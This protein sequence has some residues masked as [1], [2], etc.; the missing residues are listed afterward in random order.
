M[1]K[2]KSK[3]NKLE[4]TEKEPKITIPEEEEFFWSNYEE[5]WPYPDDDKTFEHE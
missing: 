4:E 3:L 5:G 1:S 2:R